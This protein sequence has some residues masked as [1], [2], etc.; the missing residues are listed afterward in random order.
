MLRFVMFSIC[1]ARGRLSTILDGPAIDDDNTSLNNIADLYYKPL[2]NC[3]FVDYQGLNDQ[4]TSTVPTDSSIDAR[5]LWCILPLLSSS[6]LSPIAY[7]S[8]SLS[9]ATRL[10]CFLRSVG[11]RPLNP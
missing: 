7:V 2:G 8:D 5:Q 3:I 4:A 1:G 10:R 6:P 9:L 11:F